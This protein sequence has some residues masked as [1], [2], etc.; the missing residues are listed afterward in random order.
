MFYHYC[1]DIDGERKLIEYIRKFGVKCKFSKPRQ[2][3]NIVSD[4]IQGTDLISVTL[5]I[6]ERRR[7]WPTQRIDF[8]DYSKADQY[9][10]NVSFLKKL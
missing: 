9:N 3:S 7:K 2:Q 8:S 10:I 5:N 1:Y 6:T 4:S